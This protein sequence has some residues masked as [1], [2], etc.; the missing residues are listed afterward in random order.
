M[1][2][3][4]LLLRHR[5]VHL[6]SR[7]IAVPPLWLISSPYSFLRQGNMRKFSCLSRRDVE[8]G[9]VP[10]LIAGSG[11]PLRVHLANGFVQSAI[12]EPP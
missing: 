8:N 3:Q 10:L 7:C 5:C 4:S 12:L 2:L 6:F 11:D 1:P 9:R